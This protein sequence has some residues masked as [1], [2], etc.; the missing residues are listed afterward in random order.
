MSAKLKLIYT[1]IEKLRWFVWWQLLESPIQATLK[2]NSNKGGAV[3]SINTLTAKSWRSLSSRSAVSKGP[4]DV[5]KVYLL[6]L[7][8]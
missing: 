1:Q 8:A 3:N 6:F 5:T 4:N 7:F 2:Q